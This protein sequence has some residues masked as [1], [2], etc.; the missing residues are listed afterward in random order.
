[1]FGK[2][3]AQPIA[4][5]DPVSVKPKPS[6]ECLKVDLKVL[7]I[8][9][10]LSLFL[11]AALGGYFSYFILHR[12]EERIEEIS[13]ESITSQIQDVATHSI[14]AKVKYL[15]S[16][17]VFLK[18][19][20]PLES[21]PNCTVDINDYNTFAT[22]FIVAA[23]ITTCNHE[24]L[25]GS[26]EIDS[27][28]AHAADFYASSGYDDVADVVRRGVFAVNDTTFK[29]YRVVAPYPYGENPFILPIL[30]IVHPRENA[31]ALM[32]NIYSGKDRV[33]GIDPI[34]KCLRAIHPQ[35]P[36][37]FSI[38]DIGERC[39]V[40]SKVIKLVEDVEFR[41]AVLMMYPMMLHVDNISDVSADFLS[42]KLTIE[43]NGQTYV[44]VGSLTAIFYWDKV[45][46]QSVSQKT[47]GLDI[48]LSDGSNDYYY[49]FED[50]IAVYHAGKT[51]SKESH[52][53]ASF[54][55][56]NTLF[57][58]NFTYS[59]IIQADSTFSSKYYT[60]GP[61]FAS[62]LYMS[63]I[64]FCIVIYYL[65]DIQTNK[66]WAQNDQAKRNFVRYISHGESIVSFIL[67]CVHSFCSM[68]FYKYCNQKQQHQR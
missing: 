18:S 13:F 60:N 44:H 31:R 1:M 42:N 64:A 6:N 39:M 11:T 9:L 30:Q 38:D 41:P 19:N 8:T 5:A 28:V 67:V 23:G 66:Q 7:R 14:A 40:V 36:A 10:F 22:G 53:D 43:V 59:L 50:G 20:C 33:S 65:Y 57:N 16:Y 68:Y 29:V 48:C 61:I 49:T 2:Y 35:Q 17:R 56:T 55:I 46:T 21:W 3:L 47:D 15:H 4:P 12:Q 26:N 51:L 32:F 24:A 52:L 25:V 34:Y 58:V 54:P 62:I 63:A 37:N 27:F 45:L